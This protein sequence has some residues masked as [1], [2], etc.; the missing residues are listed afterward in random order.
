MTLASILRMRM[1]RVVLAFAVL[2]SALVLIPGSDYAEAAGDPNVSFAKTAPGEA[3]AGDPAI[4]VT[5][6]ATNLSSTT[7]GFNL[8]FV[9][10]LQPGVSFVSSDPAPTQILTD[11][12]HSGET[13]LVWRNVADLQ[14]G[15]TQSLKYT[16]SAGSLPV[17]TVISNSQ[18]GH[19]HPAGAY[20]NR[21][22]R[23]VP[24]YNTTTNNV[25]GGD[26]W[27]TDGAS[28]LLVPFLLSKNEGNTEAEL[29]RGLHDHQTVYTLEIENNHLGASTDFAI[30]DWLPAGMEFLGCG[31]VDN[32]SGFEPGSSGPINPGNEPALSNCIAPD[33]VETVE[34]DPP[35]PLP[36][37]VYTHVVWNV[38][39]LAT[40]IPQ[41]GSVTYDYIAAIPLYENLLWSDP[42]VTAAEP[43]T[44]GEQGSNID[45]NLG[46]S[47]EETGTELA[48]TN[49]AWLTGTYSGSLYDDYDA[50]TVS[51]ED[52]SIH[53]S[54]GQGVIQHGIDTTW[55]LEVET[56]EYVG[57]ATAL[58]VTDTVPDGLCPVPGCGASG[59]PSP[60][61]NLATENSDGTWT[62]VWNLADMGASETTIITFPTVA[63]SYYREGFADDT[64]VLSNDSWTN[65]VHI[66]G[67]VDGRAVEDVSAD[68]QSA[69][70]VT[71]SKQVASRVDPM[72]SCGD[73]SGLTWNDTQADGYR[74]GDR[75]CWR[76]GIDFPVNLDTFDSDIQD[77]LPPG[78]EY[79][80]S[81]FWDFGDNNTVPTADIAGPGAGTGESVLT[82]SVGD[83]SGYV[84]Q[85]L[86]FEVVFSS[87]IIDATATSSGEIV[88]NLMKYSWVNTAGTPFNLRDLADVEVLEAEL[89][90]VKGVAA[91]NG[92]STGGN[93]VDGV[94]VTETDAIT[95]QL[96]I[97]ND[98]DI[99]AND[100][101][102]W[103]LLP[104][105]YSTCATNVTFIS[106]S[107]S[108]ATDTRIEWSGLSVPA[109]GSIAVTYD[110]AFPNGV[111]PDE[112]IINE[113]GVR[114]YTSDTNNGAGT[115]TYY[116]ASNIDPAVTTPNAAVADDT[117]S[118]VT[119]EA[120]ITKTRTTSVDETGNAL[121][122]E[123]TIGECVAGCQPPALG[124]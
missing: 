24:S 117:S 84:A 40:S 47:T 16:I 108:C 51:S 95:Y 15:V 118:V 9:D 96:T 4:E 60:A 111:A 5:L 76:L 103:D 43:A 7:D 66:A 18:P 25:D 53:K 120:T 119:P 93:N 38:G 101:E 2:L 39:T 72:N 104:A 29:L 6:T 33:V 90:L 73:G 79:T 124:P 71:I 116:P 121:S 12:P 82:W 68:S 115:Y 97:T 45:N 26:G 122:N 41:S 102:V 83:G 37:D 110:V 106:D 19:D 94:E 61:Y 22:P 36:L 44:T 54:A 28:T 81:D 55:T 59:T 100:V 21:D 10:V 34:V 42:L 56:S 64:P 3:L 91:V 88:E 63:L 89:D 80:A 85:N 1:V 62:L 13:T 48:M 69:G 32:S 57:T 114:S 87:T 107:G 98:G 112:T 27:D 8:T 67:T 58:V 105:E 77:Y 78:H 14:A 17:G 75:V 35:G 30:E 46:D 52:L 70:P 113:A 99:A 74:I 109:G 92:S 65:N 49:G 11:T 23:V 50:M 20:V 31:G 123:A 86:Y